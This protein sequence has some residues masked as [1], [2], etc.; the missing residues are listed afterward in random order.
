MVGAA[1]VYPLLRWIVLLPLFAA[2]LHGVLI[3]L[4]RRPLP[5]SVVI[6]VSC[7]R[8]T[9]P[10][11]A[12]NTLS[13]SRRRS[14][15]PIWWNRSSRHATWGMA[16]MIHRTLLITQRGFPVGTTYWST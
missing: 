11:L 4:V 16:A 6:A 1:E 7:S 15:P 2:A 3:G 12:R 14:S 5:R 10:V 8:I 9:K 13:C